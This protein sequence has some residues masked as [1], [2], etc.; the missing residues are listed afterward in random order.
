PARTAEVM[1][2]KDSLGVVGEISP[3]VLA[4]FG[5]KGR[6]V[7][8]DLDFRELAKRASKAKK[9]TPIPKY[10]A[11]VEDLTFVVP[12]KTL[13]G[14]MFE[15]IEK[16]SQLIKLTELIDSYKNTRTFRIT[17]QSPKKTLTDKEV[18]KIRGKIVHKLKTKFEA[19]LK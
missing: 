2:K 16:A 13:V 11:I 10:P 6:V 4:R 19:K 15:E 18:E 7:V 17:Y 1:V 9:Y 8:F 12:P 14:E 5:V 3:H